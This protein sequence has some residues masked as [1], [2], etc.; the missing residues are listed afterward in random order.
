MDRSQPREGRGPPVSAPANPSPP[1]AEQAARILGEAWADPQWGTLVWL[2]MITGMR[3]GELCGLRWSH[4]DLDAGVIR[5]STAIAYDRKTRQ[6]YE[7]GTKTH[8]R[9]HIVLDE[10]SVAALKGYKTACE[11]TAQSLGSTLT[12]D[13]FLFSPDP[14]HRVPWTPGVVTTRYSRMAR[15][16]GIRSSIHKL[17]HYSATELIAAGVDI[18]TIAG[19]LG[20]SGGGATTLRFYSAFVA[21]ADQRAAQSLAG[22][23]PKPPVEL[24]SSESRHTAAK[25][26]VRNSDRDVAPYEQIA[27]DLRGAIT[28]GVLRPGDNLPT[29]KELATRYWVGVG[30][31]H[32]AIGQLAETGLVHVSRGRRATVSAP[33]SGG[34]N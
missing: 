14:S 28:C 31:A 23:M 13:A 33:A 10:Y 15:K 4:V 27:A 16:L 7:K 22:R 3:R 2:A 5:L 25:T 1:T 11:S 6:L 29:V 32:R 19:R 17:R 9:R 30:T 34:E 21:E 24:G 12:D 8:Q 18:R 20:H 26:T